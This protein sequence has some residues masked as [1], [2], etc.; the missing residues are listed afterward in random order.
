VKA[1]K[2]D[3]DAERWSKLYESLNLNLALCYTKQRNFEAAVDS[4][5]EVLSSNPSNVKAIYRR[6]VAHTHLKNYDQAKLDLELGTQSSR[7]QNHR[8]SSSPNI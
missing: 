1:N 8:C 7:P 2:A 6:G 5:N 4:C 3:V